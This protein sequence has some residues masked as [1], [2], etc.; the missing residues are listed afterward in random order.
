MPAGRRSG[1]LRR[2][3]CVDCSIKRARVAALQM[4]LSAGAAY[5]RWQNSAGPRGRPRRKVTEE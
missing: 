1:A 4:H 3:V 2:K 5:D